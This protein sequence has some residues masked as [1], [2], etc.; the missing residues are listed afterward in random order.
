MGKFCGKCGTAIPEGTNRCPS[1]GFDPT[2]PEILNDVGDI[3]IRCCK[4]G[5]SGGRLTKLADEDIRITNGTECFNKLIWT[6]DEFGTGADKSGERDFEF[7]CTVGDGEGSMVLPVDLSDTEVPYRIGAM[8][9][10]DLKLHF[11]IGSDADNLEYV[12]EFLPSE[13]DDE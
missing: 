6:A 8:I 4:Y 1:C 7:F 2:I 11:Y 10:D 5:I 12:C 3:G 9:T 13:T